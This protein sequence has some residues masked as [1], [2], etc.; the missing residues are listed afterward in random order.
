MTP[1][2]YEERYGFPRQYVYWIVAWGVLMLAA[3]LAMVARLLSPAA[4]WI[5]IGFI[6]GIGTLVV[7]LWLRVRGWLIVRADAAGMTLRGGRIRHSDRFFP[8]ADVE[9]VWLWDDGRLKHVGVQVRQVGP[10]ESRPRPSW[11]QGVVAR[12]VERR[13]IA[14]ERWQVDEAALVSAVHRAAPRVAVYRARRGRAPE[15]LS[16]AEP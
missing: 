12:D 4:A 6:G 1:T 13:S 11:L 10:A 9:S 14:T 15:L 2:A 5:A 8:W 3:A 7:L 16:P